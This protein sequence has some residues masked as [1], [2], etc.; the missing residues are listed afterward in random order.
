MATATQTPAPRALIEIGVVVAGPLDPIDRRAITQALQ[1]VRAFLDQEFPDFEFDLLEWR[2][3]ELANG[4]RIEPSV[5]LQQA[6]EDRDQ[7]RWDFVF[8]VTAAELQ[9]HYSSYCFAALSRPLD[10]AAVSLALIDPA[11]DGEEVDDAQRE[12]RIAYRLSRLMLHALGHLTGPDKAS[13]QTRPCSDPPP[14]AT[15]M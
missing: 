9:G 15:W 1:Q 4:A 5:L 11:A 12:E 2:R 14:H 8:V 13:V 10:A 6:V 7:K 3:P